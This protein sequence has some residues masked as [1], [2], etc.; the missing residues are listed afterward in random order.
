MNDRLL[1][2]SAAACL[3]AAALPVLSGCASTHAYFS[4]ST[5]EPLIDLNARSGDTALVPNPG[6]GAVIVG[7]AYDA[8][9]DRLYA[10]VAPGDRVREVRRSDGKVLRDIE[11]RGVPAGCGYV[12]TS[13]DGLERLESGPQCGLAVRERDGHLFLDDP[14]PAAGKIYEVDLQGAVVR[15]IRLQQSAPL[16]IGD[17]GF[18]QRRET[19]FVLRVVDR[20]VDEVDM[21]GAILRHFTLEAV[22][23]PSGLAVDSVHDELVG[24][25]P[26]GADAW[27]YDLDGR[28]LRTRPLHRPVAGAIGGI[29]AGRRG[30]ALWP[31]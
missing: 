5:A 11:A 14:D 28:R 18:H 4:A 22:A 25:S 8:R 24:A 10:R 27:F 6:G 3:L 2:P 9:R 21:N 12:K 20:A 29:A 26:D 17:L 13:V 7:L 30:W 15:E 16:P 19:L 1:A 23:N 31:W